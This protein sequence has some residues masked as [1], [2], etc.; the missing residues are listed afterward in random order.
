M[1]FFGMKKLMERKVLNNAFSKKPASIPKSILKN[2]NVDVEDFK[3]RKIWTISP[4]NKE[5][6]TL[7]FFLH[8]GAYYANITT[9]HWRFIEQLLN[10]I[11]ATFIVP[12]YPLAP[13]SKCNETYKFLDE[14]YSKLINKYSSQQIVFM[15]DSA[16]GGLA[17][18]FAH[19]IRE[20]GIKQPEQIIL[21]S[22][23]LDLSMT[24]PEISRLDKHDKILSIS[25]LKMAGENYAG[26]LSLKDFRISPIYG[27]FSLLGK[28][29]VFT[30]TN[31]ILNADAQKFKKLLESQNIQF[32]YFQY[33]KMFHDWVLI[34]NLKETKEVIKMITKHILPAESK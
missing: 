30:G 29:S 22:P 32:N 31:D 8:G 28:I 6:N 21:F 9:M 4:K 14:V 25:G 12:D 3:S 15:G 1:G 27:D 34:S 33:P 2:Y 13:E 7:I 19:K 17:I 24:N 5:S 11:K 23:W 26:D 10:S 18:G 16:G 20:E